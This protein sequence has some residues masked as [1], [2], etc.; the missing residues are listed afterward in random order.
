MKM[1]STKGVGGDPHCGAAHRSRCR[2]D[3]TQLFSCIAA[4]AL[5]GEVGEFFVIA[6]TSSGLLM[7]SMHPA[8]N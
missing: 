7:I 8:R 3:L 4:T 5:I 1:R 2:A 6:Y